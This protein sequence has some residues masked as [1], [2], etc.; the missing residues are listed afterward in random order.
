LSGKCQGISECLDSGHPANTLL[1]AQN[2]P[3]IQHP[4]KEL[5]A[6]GFSER[7]QQRMK[8]KEMKQ[9]KREEGRQ[10]CGNSLQVLKEP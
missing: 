3:K 10:G 2:V 1:S 7:T 6:F 9:G 5:T 8:S 4:L